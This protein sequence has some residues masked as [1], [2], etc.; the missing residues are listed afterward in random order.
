MATVQLLDNNLIVA[1]QPLAG[2]TAVSVSG[3]AGHDNLTVDFAGGVP[4]PA[5]GLA[6]DGGGSTNVA[7]PCSMISLARPSTLAPASPS[8]R[9]AKIAPYTASLSWLAIWAAA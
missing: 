3:A 4:V 5:G 6:F 7:F 8:A 2:T 1:Q 9:K